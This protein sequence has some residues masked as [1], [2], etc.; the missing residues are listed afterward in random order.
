MADCRAGA[1]AAES[2][3]AAMLARAGLNRLAWLTPPSPWSAMGACERPGELV[4]VDMKR[5][6]R[7]A[8]WGIGS[9]A[10]AAP[11]PGHRLGNGACLRR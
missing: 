2:T 8:Q 5:L 11:G 1:S 9:T 10:I 3:V 7:I 6:G 4:H